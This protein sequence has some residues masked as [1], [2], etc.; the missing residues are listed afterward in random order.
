M[1]YQ[2]YGYAPEPEPVE[3]FDD[4]EEAAVRCEELVHED[5]YDSGE[6][7]DD[8][9][10]MVYRSGRRPATLAHAV[11]GVLTAPGRPARRGRR[12]V[13]AWGIERER[14][15]RIVRDDD[16]HAAPRE[17]RPAPAAPPE[18]PGHSAPPALAPDAPHAPEPPDPA[19]SAPAVWVL[20][21]RTAAPEVWFGDSA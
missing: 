14:P 1:T 9:G 16:G 11:L 20:G 13:H 17:G 10:E 4:L 18:R 21:D 12:A 3:C 19:A 5:G 6:V 8:D 7:W 2:L 15:I